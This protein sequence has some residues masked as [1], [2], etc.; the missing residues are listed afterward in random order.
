MSASREK[1]RRK[2]ATETAAPAPEK[3][4]KS[5]ALKWVIGI[6]IAVVVVCLLVGSYL[7]SSNWFAGHSTALTVGSHNVTAAEYNYYY[8]EVYYQ[9]S[10]MLGDNE[11]TLKMLAGSMISQTNTRI[12]QTYAV[13][14]AAV[15]DGFALPA[16]DV[17]AI[18]QEIA[19]LNTTAASYGY[20][21]ANAL[22]A[23]MY[24]A[25]CTTDSYRQYDLTVHT[26]SD[27]VSDKFEYTDEEVKAY[28]A[29][30]KDELG[31]ERDYRTVNVRHILVEDEQTAQD[32]L[33]QYLDGDKT[34]D[35]FGELA[36]E[37]STD[38][39]ADN[40]GLMEGVTPGQTV[41][42]FN[43]WIFDQSRKTG[44]TD[45][46]QTEYGYHVMYFVGEGENTFDATVR[47]TMKNEAYNAWVDELTADY[48][49][50]EHSF[51]MKLTSAIQPEPVEETS[52]EE[53]AEETTEEATETAAAETTETAAAETT[54]TA[55][56]A[57]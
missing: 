8:R 30:H 6:V 17:E 7:L 49:I 41:E 48:P 38:G 57:G 53:T 40:G 13:Y 28:Y 35:S 22:L 16:E 33:Q 25:G 19:D 12:Q 46:V 15:A 52:E 42:A 43:E 36:M 55:Q 32:I 45:I 11:D 39:S 26:V 24:G 3:K 44:D 4:Q 34:E 21:G 23:A 2:D 20:S 54:E 9:Y 18:D 51:G 56:A 29:E 27:Y 10:Q 5:A 14:D 47:D 37:Y 1:Q 50:T 31:E